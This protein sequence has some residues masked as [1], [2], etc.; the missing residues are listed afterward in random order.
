[1]D[2]VL[3]QMKPYDNHMEAAEVKNC[4]QSG[5][6][7]YSPEQLAYLPGASLANIIW[8]SWDTVP[9]ERPKIPQFLETLR[10]L[11]TAWGISLAPAKASDTMDC[12]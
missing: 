9:S 12:Y 10:S 6:R 1:M 4:L 3:T 8:M 2:Q 7:P 11:A 5:G